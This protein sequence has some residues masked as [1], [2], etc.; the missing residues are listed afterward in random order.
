MPRIDSSFY[1]HVI[2]CDYCEWRTVAPT[3]ATAW[4][5]LAVHLKGAHNDAPAASHALEMMRRRSR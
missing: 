1:S 3:P 5:L 4:K 2:G